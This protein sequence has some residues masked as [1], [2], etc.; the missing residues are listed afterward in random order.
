MSLIQHG[1]FPRSMFDTDY[2][3][4]PQSLTVGLPTSTLDIFDPFDELV[5]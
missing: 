3:Y 1:L 4:R 5:S 2:W